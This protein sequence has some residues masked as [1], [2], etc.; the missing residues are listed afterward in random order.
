MQDVAGS[1]LADFAKSLSEMMA[2]EREGGAA[3]AE[4][5]PAEPSQLGKEALNLTEAVGGMLRQRLAKWTGLAALNRL[6][7]RRR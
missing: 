2:A 6:F 4:V 3:P 5:P 1:M 7:S